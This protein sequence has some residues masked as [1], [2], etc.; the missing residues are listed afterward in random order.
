MGV[1]CEVK[2]EKSKASNKLYFDKKL[3]QFS[4]EFKR[5]GVIE[6]LK[7]HRYYMKPSKRKRL[8]REISAAKWKYY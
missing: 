1:N 2:L 6:V 3:K 4:N 7:L 8:S 5:S